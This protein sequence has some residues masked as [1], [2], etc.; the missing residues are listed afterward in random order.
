MTTL[1]ASLSIRSRMSPRALHWVSGT[2][3]AAGLY[4]AAYAQTP[5]AAEETISLPAFTIRD[6]R[7]SAYG[8]KEAIST[9]RVSVPIQDVPQTVSV[10][11]RELIDDTLGFRMLDVAKYVTPIMESSLVSGGDRVTLRGFQVTQRFID[12]VNISGVDGYNMTSDTSNVERIEVIKGPNAILVPGGSP[13]GIMNQITKAPKF[14]NFGSVSLVVKTYLGSQA[15]AD[16]NRVFNDKKSA[17]RVVASAWDSDGYFRGQFRKG[18]LIAP[19]F[20]HVFKNGVEFTSKLEDL[21]NEETQG[22]GAVIDPS[23]GSGQYARVAPGVPRN[24]SWVPESDSRRRW[25]TRWTNELRIP[26]GDVISSRLW[27]MADHAERNDRGAP[28]GTPA[29][30]FQ[31]ARNPLT[32]MWEPFKTFASTAPYTA[33]TLVPSTS[34]IYNRTGQANLIKFNELHLKNDYAMDYAFSDAVKTTTIAGF[35]ANHSRLSWKNWSNTRAPLDIANPVYDTPILTS[36]LLR[37]K[38][39]AQQDFQVFVYERLTLLNDK[40]ILAGGASKFWGTLERLDDGNLPAVV[41]RS[42]SNDV[43][44]SNIGAIIKPIKEVSLFAGYNKVGGALPSSI[45]AGE[46]PRTFRIQVGDQIEYGV[47]T[48][49]K[50]GRINASF[51]HFDISQNNF[52]VPNSAFNTDPTQP[53]FL[54]LDLTSKGWEFEFNTLLTRELTLIGNYTRFKTRDPNG[55]RQRMVPDKAGALWLKYQ[56]VDGP[57]KGFSVSLGVDYMGDAAGEQVASVSPASTA[58]NVIPN[59][60]SFLVAGRTILQLGLGYTRKDWTFHVN[61]ANLTDKDYIQSAGAR[62]VLIPGEPRNISGAVT[63][64]F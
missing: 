63:Y 22:V 55:V 32:G 50:D 2:V 40:L 64:K 33:T 57:A 15:T 10:V 23:V 44:D 26:I 47:K 61:V 59:Q 58:T 7:S 45:L 13:G 16:V 54:F 19:S 48:S 35:S 14:E 1:T 38:V 37:D 49:F 36:T 12:G 8:A 60:P 20:T 6:T 43:T 52:Q 41:A 62:N 42:I 18:Y 29:V 39:A 24:N 30:G 53:Q 51:S 11:T 46:Q 31:G 27:F 34:T 3:I 28:G 9:T 17:V 56:L 21:Y 5:P 25:E 4:G